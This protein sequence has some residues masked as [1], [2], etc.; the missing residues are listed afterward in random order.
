MQSIQDILDKKIALGFSWFYGSVDDEGYLRR[1]LHTNP[2]IERL[3]MQLKDD[4]EFVKNIDKGYFRYNW[5]MGAFK[6]LK[7]H[8]EEA[9]GYVATQ[10]YKKTKRTQAEQE[11]IESEIE[12]LEKDLRNDLI[13]KDEYDYAVK[14][15][16]QPAAD[17]LDEI[18]SK[19]EEI[20]RKVKKE[21][22]K[23]GYE[24][25]NM[26]FDEEK[27]D[28]EYIFPE[29]ESPAAP[30]EPFESKK[31]DINKLVDENNRRYSMTEFNDL[32][33]DME[34]VEEIITPTQAPAAAADPVT[35]KI[36]ANQEKLRRDAINSLIKGKKLPP[37]IQQAQL[38]KMTI[39]Q[40][41]ALTKA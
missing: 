23:Y 26:E 1:L 4:I 32:Y 17:N 15:L 21:L 5:Q 36:V 40:L 30:E 24:E 16:L 11:D 41:V 12:S 33:E 18:K 2:S 3:H 22:K 34:K 20:D 6:S 38:Q 7:K 27:G 13:D 19:F 10:V 31:A 29:D 39:D 9:K 35:K 8:L 14:M 28:E 25:E 37:N